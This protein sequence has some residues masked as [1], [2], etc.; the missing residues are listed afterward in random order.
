MG[1]GRGMKSY[2]VF[3]EGWW[4]YLRSGFVLKEHIWDLTK[5]SLLEKVSL[6]RYNSRLRVSSKGGGGGGGGHRGRSPPP[7]KA[8][9][10]HYMKHVQWYRLREYNVED[11][12]Y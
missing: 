12:Y 1:A 3:I 11:I 10:P 7:P 4:P 8:E 9:L 5:V 2:M 6:D